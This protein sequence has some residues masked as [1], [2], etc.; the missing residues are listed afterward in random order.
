MKSL[1]YRQQPRVEAHPFA[2]PRRKHVTCAAAIIS[3]AKIAEAKSILLDAIAPTNRGG[4]A[5]STQRC[6]VLDAQ[7]VGS[8]CLLTA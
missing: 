3:N 7:V 4:T 2:L 1:S 6:A 8:N 5:S